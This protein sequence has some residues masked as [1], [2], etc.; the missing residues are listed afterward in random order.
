[1]LALPSPPVDS[2][3]RFAAG[4]RGDHDFVEIVAGVGQCVAGG[5]FGGLRGSQ[6]GGQHQ[7]DGPGQGRSEG[8]GAQ[9]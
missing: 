1:M 4:G 8:M 3:F 5:R 7:A 9:R 6:T 2:E